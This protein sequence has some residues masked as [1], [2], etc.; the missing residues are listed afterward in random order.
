[1]AGAI[2]A[3]GSLFA[4]L[5]LFTPDMSGRDRGNPYLGIL[6]RVVAPFFL[7]LGLVVALFGVRRRRREL[8]MLNSAAEGECRPIWPFSWGDYP[9]LGEAFALAEDGA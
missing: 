3:S 5:L 8:A 7:A 9:P 2:V 4:I 1:V 6:C